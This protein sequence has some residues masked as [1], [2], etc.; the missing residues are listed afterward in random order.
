MSE[1]VVSSSLGS[2]D[3]Y[4]TMSLIGY[5]SGLFNRFVGLVAWM[6]DI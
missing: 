1:W 6:K 5:L 4:L 3:G 2:W